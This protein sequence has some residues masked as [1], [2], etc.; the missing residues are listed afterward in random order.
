MACKTLDTNRQHPLARLAAAYEASP[1][2]KEASPL[3]D[4]LAEECLAWDVIQDEERANERI[5]VLLKYP[6]IYRFLLCQPLLGLVDLSEWTHRLPEGLNRID[7]VIAGGESGPSARAMLPGL[8]KAI[9]R[10]MS[11]GRDSFSFQTV[12]TL[13]TGSRT[14]T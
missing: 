9:A 12:G 10:S 11:T 6:A 7:W 4:S 8:G 2:R 13:G 5:P 1:E 3:D 14:K